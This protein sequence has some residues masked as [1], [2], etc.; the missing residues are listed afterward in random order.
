MCVCALIDTK[1][2]RLR[3]REI[4]STLPITYYVFL[5]HLIRFA[6]SVRP[7]QAPAQAG[8]NV[9]IAI[10]RRVASTVTPVWP[11]LLPAACFVT[12]RHVAWACV[13]S[14]PQKPGFRDHRQHRLDRRPSRACAPFATRG[15]VL[16]L[17][18]GDLLC[19]FSLLISHFSFRPIRCPLA[20]THPG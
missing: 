10:S 1:K 4:D 9:R 8:G 6:S 3:T 20:F 14:W 2:P 5:S 11:E 13:A 15:G 12:R 16:H 7:Y 18:S 17:V 19:L